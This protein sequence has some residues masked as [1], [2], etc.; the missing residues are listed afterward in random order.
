MKRYI[1][2]AA[3]FYKIK[4]ELDQTVIWRKLGEDKIEV[5]PI[6]KHSRELIERIIEKQNSHV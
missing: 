5:R 4:P 2:S 6:F 3:T 1:I